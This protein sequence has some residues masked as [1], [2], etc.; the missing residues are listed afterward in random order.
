MGVRLPAGAAARLFA[1]LLVPP[2]SSA[3]Q[4]L[5][6]VVHPFNVAT[7]GDTPIQVMQASDGNF[8]GVTHYFGPADGRGTVYRMTPTGEVTVLHT[9]HGGTSDGEEPKGGVIKASDGNLYGTTAFGGQYSRGIVYRVSLTGD[10]AI[11]HHFS[12]PDGGYPTAELIQGSD[13]ALYGVTYGGGSFDRGTAFRLP[14][15]GPLTTLHHFAGGASDAANPGTA[16]VAYNGAFYGLSNF[17][18]TV[19]YGVGTIYRMTADGTVTVLQSIDTFD[20]DYSF[21]GVAGLLPASDGYLYGIVRNSCKGQNGYIFR[22]GAD[23]AFTRLRDLPNCSAAPHS[24]FIEGGDG[25]LYSMGYRGVFR[26]TRDGG[27]SLVHSLRYNIEGSYFGGSM[28]QAGDGHLYGT[29]TGGATIAGS[30]FRLRTSP[31]GRPE[32]VSVRRRSDGVALQWPSVFG[33]ASYIVKRG[34]E[35]AQETVIATGVTTTWFVDTTPGAT[36]A[37]YYIVTA[38][39]L[40]GGTID[41]LEVAAPLTS[42]RAAADFDHD[43]RSDLTVYRPGSGEWRSRRSIAGGDEIRTWGGVGGDVPVA[44]DYDGDG[45]TDVS[46]WRPTRSPARWYFHSGGGADWGVAGDI[47]VPADYDGD[48]RAEVAVFRPSTGAWWIPG[49]ATVIWGAAGDIPVAADYDGDGRTDIAVYRP[50]TGT[51]YVRNILARTYG[52]S[53]DIPVPADYDGDGRA[54]IAVFRPA[55][56]TWYVEDQFTMRWGASGDLPVPLDRDGDGR[57]ELGVF[58]RATGTWYFKNR[59]TDANETVVWG[60][61]GD[62]PIGTSTPLLR[63]VIG[64][65]DGDRQADPAVFRPSTGEWFLLRS[66]SNRR[67]SIV[68][69]WGLTTDIAV[70]RDYDGDGT[71]DPAVYRP[72]LGRWFVLQSSS[73]FTTSTIR[74]WGLSTDTPVPADY[75][76]DG[77]ADFAVFRESSGQ[78]WLLLSSTG[79]SVTIDWGTTGDLPVPADYDG[80]GRVD[81]AVFRPSTG[82]WY[83]RNRFLNTTTTRDW[84]L[85]GDVPVP[86]DYDGDGRADVAVFRPLQNR[87][88]IVPSLVGVPQT[89]DFG[90]S[91]D[92]PAPADYDGDG[93]TDLA[94]F[95][96]SDGTWDV[97]GIFTQVWGVSGDVP[98]IR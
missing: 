37:N 16:L 31:E 26:V 35:V 55:T 72:L 48:G 67:D 77:K 34:H 65:V 33:A 95:R 90:V 40:W 17:G 44:A 87:W 20:G 12:G 89:I 41:S 94:V 42:S 96:P 66:A 39:G 43:G 57:L 82:R 78:W 88:Y 47:P 6:E 56:G 32:S 86:A 29:A 45:I 23:G 3:A 49:A 30:V 7:E 50:A 14:L 60:A 79:A 54:D 81:P 71:L 4:N 11:L 21:L 98:A 38:V 19:W 84:G 83:I 74:D 1:V 70:A 61:P 73:V 8:Y 93:K 58:R 80:D 13:G 51:W 52:I 91:G 27:T 63:P 85:A 64:T 2:A 62:L 25:A 24:R 75:D 36:E 76:G 46:I 59:V 28:Y 68:R 22:L 9:F 53:G 10:F 97:R 15:S 5:V 69:T 92:I 18:G